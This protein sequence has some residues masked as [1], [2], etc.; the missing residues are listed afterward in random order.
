MR[1]PFRKGAKS[2]PATTSQ[3]RKYLI[4]IIVLLSLPFI[5]SM[6]PSKELLDPYRRDVYGN[7]VPLED[8]FWEYQI[9]LFAEQYA[10]GA[11]LV[12][13][14]SW[15]VAVPFI[16]KIEVT[17]YLIR[18]SPGTW[19]WDPSN[20][21]SVDNA[22]EYIDP[23]ED[24]TK[25]ADIRKRAADA[26]RNM[27]NPGYLGHVNVQDALERRLFA[28]N[29]IY[30][31]ESIGNPDRGFPVFDT[32]TL[33]SHGDP[34]KVLAQA[35]GAMEWKG[36]PVDNVNVTVATFVRIR[37]KKYPDEPRPIFYLADCPEMWKWYQKRARIHE[38]TEKDAE[39][40]GRATDRNI[41][42]EAQ[43]E[44]RDAEEKIAATASARAKSNLQRSI[45]EGVDEEV[46]A[47]G[48][49]LNWKRPGMR[50]ALR[51]NWLPIAFVIVVLIAV[52]AFLMLYG[53]IPIEGGEAMVT[54]TTQATQTTTTATGVYTGPTTIQPGGG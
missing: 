7:P 41:A 39:E 3:S 22:I 27:G 18:L 5:V 16:R 51:R 13:V 10:G 48:G 38:P 29:D 28:V 54:T 25:R 44:R 9:R 36:E 21:I 8:R 47:V 17:G 33:V 45:Y 30:L 15:I 34:H 20:W 14:I 50:S 46:E 23:I 19:V 6:F 32:F 35:K 4:V 40:A 11:A 26:L 43:Q 24:P 52:V 31:V 49:I 42:I 1:I 53:I 12:I 37:S 2:K